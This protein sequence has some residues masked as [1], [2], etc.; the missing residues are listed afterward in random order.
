MKL[1]LFGPYPLDP[2]CCGGAESH[3][4]NLVEHLQKI[5]DLEVHVVT[6]ASHKKI[7]TQY[8]TEHLQI[9]VI[10]KSK[11]PMTFAGVFIY[12]VKMLVIA[13]RIKPDLVHGQMVG[14]PYGFATALLSKTHRTVLTIH[15]LMEQSKLKRTT[16]SEK[17]HDII[18]SYLE[19]W[20][21]KTIPNLIIVSP[22]L[23][24]SIV[25]LNAKNIIFIPNGIDLTKYES[26]SS[27]DY[28]KNRLLFVGR[29]TPIKGIEFL[30]HAVSIVIERKNDVYLK[31]VGPSENKKYFKYLNDLCSQL[32]ISKY[33]EFLGPL[34]NECLIKEYFKSSIFVLPSLDESNPIV[35]L[36][37]MAAGKPIVATKVG[38]VPNLIDDGVT[39]LLVKSRNCYEFADA[40]IELLDNPYTYVNISSNCKKQ[41]KK[42]QW[43]EI[44]YETYKLY[45]E[46]FSRQ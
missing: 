6:L 8:T 26:D 29:I 5:N 38:G 37:A 39:G 1:L 14:A 34:Y 15:T 46:L 11:I 24:D 21:I 41:I 18:W 13:R 4:K 9:H 30:L 36:E 3:V 7:V 28:E 44:A 10:K 20:E 40:L 43:D 16:I 45:S 42:Y 22:H 31:I 17:I 27:Y 25:R 23:K 19:K 35:L 33:V 32:C 2:D 12:P